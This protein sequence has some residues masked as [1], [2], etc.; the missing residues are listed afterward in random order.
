MILPVPGLRSRA[1][2][3]R[4][5]ASLTEVPSL[6]V[7]VS[8]QSRV[9]CVRCMNGG[10]SLEGVVGPL[11]D[12][13]LPPDLKRAR[14]CPGASP[15]GPVV[16]AMADRAERTTIGGAVAGALRQRE[17]LLVLA[18]GMLLL[19][20]LLVHYAG[21]PDIA[22]FA[23]LA[24]SVILTSTQTFPGALRA[25]RKVS[26][27]VDVLMFVAAGGA[28]A[29]GHPEEGALLLFLFGLGAA[30]ETYAM[31][32]A[33]GAIEALSSVAP[34]EATV[35][36]DDGEETVVP[37]DRVAVG[38]RV[39]V[40]PFDRVPVDGDVED[41][42]SAVNQAPI[43]GESV[44]VDKAPGDGVFAGTI[45]GDGRLVVRV[46][47]MPSEST[48]A[49]VI[50]MVEEAQASR[51]PT[52]LFT[53]RIERW[54]VPSVFVATLAL[55]FIP[56]LVFEQ[57]WVTWFYRAMAFLTAASPCA[58]AIGTP[59]AVLCG[60][61][62]AAQLG[63]L[64]KGGG[65]LELLGRLDAVAFDKT[66][67]LTRG[68]AAVTGITP[69]PGSAFDAAG[70]L[71]LAA[72]VEAHVTHP[73]AA[74][75]LAEADRLGVTYEPAEDVQQ[76]P[77]FGAT[78]VVGG[79]PVRVGRPDDRGPIAAAAVLEEIRAEGGT[80]IAVWRDRDLLGLIGVA[81]R[82]RPEA[83]EVVVEL[84]RLGVTHLAMLT[85]DHPA[86]AQSIATRLGIDDVR[87][88]LLPED[89]LRVVD[90]LAAVHGRVAMVGDG[91]ND[92]PAL[93]QASL[94]IA[95][96]AAGADVAMETADVV[97]LGNDLRHLPQAVALSRASK[98]M[99]AQN[100]AI[101]LGVIAIVSPLA[102]LGYAGLGV[103]VLLHEGSTV[104]VVLNALRL[105]RFDRGRH[106]ETNLACDHCPLMP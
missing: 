88:E 62:R 99:I 96:G 83:A 90:E 30:G 42:R 16:W 105:L 54:Y 34:D 41:G 57:S 76:V 9:V 19:T 25:L 75:V 44:P 58:L 71:A 82:V 86:A 102:A 33:R 17:V 67:T 89:K 95:M 43:T 28:A 53:D 80:A 87:A 6:D 39:M 26:L 106:R 31:Q 48:L 11:R 18:G 14:V 38:L 74:A 61:G 24:C 92:A 78:G 46:T 32:R 59:A 65:Y 72:A 70:L 93:A 81:D 91:V 45:N 10:C 49:R 66:G 13:G 22:R 64:I 100:L 50:R 15:A 55:V 47:K 2:A 56:P 101:A 94:G 60:V 98:R 23:L 5:E 7:V 51:S 73:L 21:G 77:G 103:A 79:M 20:G 69:L 27:D 8:A 68:E 1:D 35:L 37:I 84:R 3:A 36:G 85:G 29:I 104:V 63:V 4:A 12:V 97:L 40:R 52:E